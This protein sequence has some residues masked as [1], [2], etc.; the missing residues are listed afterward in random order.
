[1]A[2]LWTSLGVCGVQCLRRPTVLLCCAREEVAQGWCRLD[3]IPA[4][5]DHGLENGMIKSLH[6]NRD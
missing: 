6:S 3:L 5:E 2:R 4:V 1:M